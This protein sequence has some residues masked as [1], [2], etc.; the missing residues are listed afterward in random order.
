MKAKWGVEVWLHF[1]L[2]SVLDEGQVF[3]PSTLPLG[4]EIPV[5]INQKA[6]WA[7]EPVSAFWRR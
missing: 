4:K 5:S 6:E 1:F 3:A 7:P 2:S